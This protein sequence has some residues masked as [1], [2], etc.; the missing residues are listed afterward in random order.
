MKN[1][2]EPWIH[3]DMGENGTVHLNYYHIT[4]V[5]DKP[6]GV[7]EVVT[8]AQTKWEFTGEMRVSFLDQWQKIVNKENE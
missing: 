2:K 6:N 4:M 1:K 3:V 7:V 8:N 5:F